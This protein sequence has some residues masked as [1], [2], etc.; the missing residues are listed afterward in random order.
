MEPGIAALI[1]RAEEIAAIDAAISSALVGHGQMVLVEGAPGL[2]K[3]S[4]LRAAAQRAQGAGMLVLGASG[5]MLEQDL[6]W[7][8]AGDVFQT[9]VERAGEDGRAPPRRSGSLRVL[10]QR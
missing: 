8:V 1:E 3:T 4:L 10:V 2:G 9:H 5:A 6:A 7:T